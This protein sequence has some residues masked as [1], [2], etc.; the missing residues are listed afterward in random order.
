MGAESFLVDYVGKSLIWKVNHRNRFEKLD[1]LVLNFLI[2]HMIHAERLTVVLAQNI[3]G[4]IDW[5]MN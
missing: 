3:F 1:R 5:N 2:C 4:S